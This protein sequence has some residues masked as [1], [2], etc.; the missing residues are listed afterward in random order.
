MKTLK[1]LIASSA[2]MACAVSAFAN[3]SLTNEIY[4]TGST[5]FRAGA[6]TAI[7]DSLNSPI[8][9][10]P[11]GGSIG[12]NQAI[13]GGTLKS[14]P[15]A[16]D[17]VYY[18]LAWAGSLGGLQ[19]AGLGEVPPAYNS[20]GV[21][22]PAFPANQNWLAPSNI[23]GLTGS[24]LTAAALS[25]STA[26]GIPVATG[27]LSLSSPAWDTD[28]SNPDAAFSDAS[29]GSTKFNYSSLK[30][31]D[32]ADGDVGIIPFVWVKGP[33]GAGVSLAAWNRFTNMSQAN[34]F[35]LLTNGSLTLNQLTG[36]SSD[37]G[38]T[39]VVNG[40]NLDSGTRFSTFAECQFGENAAP[41]QYP[42]TAGGTG[43][44]YLDSV[45][46]E[47]A[48]AGGN[49]S[50]GNITG[51]LKLPPDY[52]SQFGTNGFGPI[53]AVSYLGISDA[54]TVVTYGGGGLFNDANTATTV[55]GS[56]W[57]PGTTLSYSG[58]AAPLLLGSTFDIQLT[59]LG[60]EIETGSYSFWEYEHLYYNSTTVSGGIADVLNGIK[61]MANTLVATDATSAGL[62]LGSMVATRADEFSP[63]F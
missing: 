43:S 25:V 56:T 44:L 17:Q 11:S 30:G 15:G 24:N 60:P 4:I 26:S 49:T 40:R 32:L 14:G 20:A 2:A 36:N 1:F 3:K 38:I 9:A 19:A 50:G 51:A 7:I 6:I 21:A 18:V 13:I 22:A 46:T 31:F 34:A 12:G 58:V 54:K 27:G 10:F 57:I 8:G 47:F 5:A 37:S 48:A 55:T 62:L 42:F 53:I 29:K 45:G 33:P 39:V 28:G 52:N 23:I 41:A 63:I 59:Q 61:L 35:A 16:G